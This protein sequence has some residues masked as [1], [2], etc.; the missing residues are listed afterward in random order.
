MHD[1]LASVIT[2]ARDVH[3]AEARSGGVGH[4]SAATLEFISIVWPAL[5]K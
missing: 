1:K 2:V 3:S 4:G 5:A